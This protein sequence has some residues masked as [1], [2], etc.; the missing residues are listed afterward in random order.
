[1]TFMLMFDRLVTEAEQIRFSL[2]KFKLPS[3][4]RPAWDFQYVVEEL[5]TGKEYGFRGGLV[6]KKFINQD[7][8]LQEYESWAKAL[9]QE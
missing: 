6:W 7:D 4:Q 5:Q 9:Q 2:Y 8:C 3:V 1:M